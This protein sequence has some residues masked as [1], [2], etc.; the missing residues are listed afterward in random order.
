MVFH[1]SAFPLAHCNFWVWGEVGDGVFGFPG[2]QGWDDTWFLKSTPSSIPAGE[3][4]LH[5]DLLIREAGEGGHADEFIPGLSM[6]EQA[7]LLP[8]QKLCLWW[9]VL[10]SQHLLWEW[11]CGSGECSVLSE[12]GFSASVHWAPEFTC[13]IPVSTM[14]P[15]GLI[16]WGLVGHLLGVQKRPEQSSQ[17]FLSGQGA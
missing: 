7:R 10:M 15:D 13:I 3:S 17:S 6:C 11:K 5:F 1:R 12:T 9:I 4:Q 14:G 16:F 2:A 8:P